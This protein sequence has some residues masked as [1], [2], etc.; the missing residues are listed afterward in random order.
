VLGVGIGFAFSSLANVVVG[1]VEP[2][3]TGEATG[4]NTIVRTIGGSLG[5]QVATAVVGATTLAGT[6]LPT[7][8]GYT[9]AFG[10]SA[11]ALVV[12]ALVALAGGRGRAR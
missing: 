9:T 8:A 11:V 3:E 12:G 2:H 6:G 5:A 4:V 10:V 7:A 1:A